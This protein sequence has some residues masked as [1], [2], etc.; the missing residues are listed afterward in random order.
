MS[1]LLSVLASIWRGLD[2]LRKLLH[3]VLLLA[4]FGLVWAAFHPGSPGLPRRAALLVR[5]EGRLVEQL[6]GDPVDRALG[7]ANGSKN[8]ETLVKDLTDAIRAAA[9]DARIEA[10]VLDTSELSGGGLSKL[11]AVAAALRDFRA[12]GKKVLAHG[13]YVSQ[14]GYYLMANA[15][16]AWLEPGG[17]VV[18]DG[19]AAY[20]HYF[21]DVLDKLGVTVNVFKVGTYKSFVEQYTQPAMS[22]AD[23][24]QTEGYLKPLWAAYESAVTSARKLPA[25]ALT[26]YVQKAPEGLRAA[27][28]DAALFAEQAGLVNGRKTRIEFESRVIELVGEDPDSH[29]F[30]AVEVPQYHSVAVHGLS[31]DEGPAGTRVAVL[32]AVGEILDGDQPPGKV[33]G[34]SFARLL[35]DA[36]FDK[37]VKAVVLRVDS[38][39]G[40]VQ[41]SEV[42]RQEVDALK[43]AGKPV[44]A[45]FASVAAS[46]GYYISMDSD[47]IFAEPTT[48][49]GSIG[50]FAV[51]PTFERTL[52]KLGVATDGVATSPLAGATDL[53]RGLAP[54][55]KDVLQQGVEF[56]YGQFIGQ[57]AKSRGKTPAEIDAIAQGRV[58]IAADALSRGLIDR[59]GGLKDAIGAAAK[60]AGLKNGQYG[61]SYR[62][63]QLNWREALVR[64]VRADGMRV[65]VTAG[66]VSAPRPGLARALT[67]LDSMVDSVAAFNDPRGLYLYCPCDQR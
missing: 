60:R 66:L 18:V 24:E 49:T 53:S 33:G 25:G 58:W 15:D 41:A 52:G 23:R 2:G 17:A 30:N 61:V 35:R 8:P 12:A 32:T 22:A 46:G 55:V 47:E 10:I 59:I 4:L 63:K 9:K 13:G 54:E 48:I 20:R 28:G 40:S 57:V 65:A 21:H 1:R 36:R 44:V 37:T 45:S 16:E 67:A 29:S 7:E 56:T 62:E 50:V 27:R 19:F 51:L 26:D 11:E 38:P 6:S 5:P 31:N 34:E 39:G 14:E 42:I 3:L 43:A 64:N